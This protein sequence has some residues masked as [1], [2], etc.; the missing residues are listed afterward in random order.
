MVKRIELSGYI[1]VNCYIFSDDETKHCYIID[2]G[3]Q[4]NTVLAILKSDGLVPDCILLTH[5]HFDHIGVVNSLRIK[6]NIPVFCYSEEYVKNPDLNLS[7]QFVPF[8]VDDTLSYPAII[9]LNDGRLPL[10]VLH[11]P[12][13]TTDS[14]IL[15]SEDDGICF[16]GDTIFH[17]GI[18]SYTLPGG[19][20][21]DL[22]NSIKNIIFTL[23]ENTIL[24]PGHGEDTTVRDEIAYNKR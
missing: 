15:Y 18:G 20:Y 3:A 6:Y 1:P 8:T 14:V 19:K 5:G 16:T 17:H 10:K 7:C 22:V 2:P 24:Y 12:G 11:T 13:H 9:T 4:V 21:N 23:P